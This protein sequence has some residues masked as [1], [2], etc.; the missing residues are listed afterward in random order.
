[1][2]DGLCELDPKEKKGGPY[3][4]LENS[5]LGIDTPLYFQIEMDLRKKL[6]TGVLCPAIC[7]LEAK[8]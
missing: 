8:E 2:R 5:V 1:L 7:F 3:Q 6:L 4:F